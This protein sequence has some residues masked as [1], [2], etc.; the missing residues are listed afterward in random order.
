MPSSSRTGDAASVAKGIGSI[1]V[2]TGGSDERDGEGGSSSSTTDDAASVAKGVGSVAVGTAGWDER[3]GEDGSSS[4]KTG[5]AAFVAKGVRGRG[6]GRLLAGRN[7]GG[8]SDLV[9]AD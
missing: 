6:D 4:S 5:D 8:S 9:A 1:A 7:T 2:G 3:G